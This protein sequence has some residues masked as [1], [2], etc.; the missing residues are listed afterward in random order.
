MDKITLEKKTV[1]EAIFEGLKLLGA[2]REDVI[3]HVEEEGQKGFLGLIGG[4]DAKVTIVK[5]ALLMQLC[6]KT[7]KKKP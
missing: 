2:K 4:K 7:M 3:I 5:K 6:L 1:E